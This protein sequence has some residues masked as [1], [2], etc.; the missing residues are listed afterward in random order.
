MR[1]I[2]FLLLLLFS[3][4]H[5]DPPAGEDVRPAPRVVAADTVWS[6]S[7]EID[8]EVTV[9]E[10]ATL[11]IEEGA[12]L[13]FR[14]GGSRLIVSGR[15]ETVG[16]PARPVVFTAFPGAEEK[17]GGILL[18]AGS[19]ES[20]L[21]HC[22]VRGA[23]AVT[24]GGS[25]VIVRDCRFEDNGIALDVAAESRAEVTGAA[26]SNNDTGVGCRLQSRVIVKDSLFEG[27][28]GWAVA[29][30]NAGGGKVVGN[31]FIGGRGI[32]VRQ[33]RDVLAADNVFTNPETAILAEQVAHDVRFIGNR[34]EEGG[35]GLVAVNFANPYV[36]CG[37]FRGLAKAVTA[38]RFSRPLVSNC[39]FEGNERALE[40]TQKANFPIRDNVFHD[41]GE[42]LFLDLSAYPRIEGNS[43]SG[44]GKDIVLG[45]Y[46]SAHWEEKV[47]S[48]GI[49]LERARESR[50][51]NVGGIE[52]ERSYDGLVD[53]SGNWWGRETTSAME[54]L[55]PESDIPSIDDVFDRPKVSYPDFGP[56]EYRLD[57]VVYAPWLSGPPAG[58]GP[59]AEGCADIIPGS[60]RE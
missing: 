1:Q 36:A 16:T 38:T 30:S 44:N 35:D 53:A 3:C 41:N 14:D 24:L 34:F 29:F 4:A 11:R 12:R 6:G 51:R 47:G 17:W 42:A 28:G 27:Q 58:A 26:F 10:G 54:R 55:G 2:F 7:W 57:R 33:G 49:S 15:L 8:G 31:T 60:G 39:L 20:L 5:A 46:M 25:S 52:R 56:E 43:F 22:V 18:A 23:A 37:T 48:R 32:L 45:I 50:S 59:P 13:V 19:Q 21:S 40:A 9:Q